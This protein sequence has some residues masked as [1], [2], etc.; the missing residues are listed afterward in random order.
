MIVLGDEQAPLGP[1]L[2]EP[3]LF[4]SRFFD[5][6]PALLVFLLKHKK[7]RSTIPRLRLHGVTN[8]AVPVRRRGDDPLSYADADLYSKEA[9]FPKPPFGLDLCPQFLP[10]C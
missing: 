1:L 3:P 8:P 2:C 10:P 4:F 9:A 5:P 6:Y 7:H